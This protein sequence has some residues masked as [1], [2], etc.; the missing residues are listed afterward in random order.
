MPEA[1]EKTIDDLGSRE[2]DVLVIGGGIVGAGV[3]RDAAMRGLRAGLVEQGDFASGTSSRTSRLLHGGLRY[4]AQG[5]VGLVHEASTE[6]RTLH[7]IAP[8]LA[9]PLPLVFP[10]YRGTDWPLWQLRIGVKIYD[11]LC[12][13]KNLG[14]SSAMT[15]GHLLAHFPGLNPYNLHGAV[16]YYDGLTQDARL[17]LDTLRSAGHHGAQLANYLRFDGADFR[18]PGWDCRLIDVLSGDTFRVRTKSVVNAT[19]P[20]SPTVP[21]SGIRLRLTKGIHLVVDAARLPVPEALVMSENKRILF[22]IPWGDRMIVGTTDTEYAGPLDDVVADRDDVRYVLD[23]TNHAFPD[24]RLSADDVLGTWAGLR[25]LIAAKSGGPSDISRAHQ[26]LSSHP[27][28]IDV[29]GGKLTTYRLIAEQVVDRVLK[30]L[31]RRAEPCR[32]ADEPLLAFEPGGQAFLPVTSPGGRTFLSGQEETGKNA[33]PPVYSGILPPPKDREIVVH[34]C[35]HEWAE[36]L[37]DVMI[38][39]TSWHYESSRPGEAAPQVAAWMAEALG[40]D[41]ARQDAELRR[42]A[43][44]C[45]RENAW[46]ES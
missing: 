39:R 12:H 27:G 26:I 5:R 45:R 20:W 23:V 24:A 8:H 29:A 21:H 43:E 18:K 4:L 36:R 25:P 14:Q 16:R 15:A 19:G 40:W 44:R 41:A 11:L 10:A 2:H 6:K 22:V 9:R 42:Y 33:C 32:T 46:R 13:G 31:S 38:R 28:W 37:D 1:R 35:R 3:V 30:A 34:Y 7:H 17:V